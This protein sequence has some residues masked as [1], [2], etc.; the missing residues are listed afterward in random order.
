MDVLVRQ[1]READLEAL[2][3]IHAD[4]RTNVHWPEGAFKEM[5]QARK[6]LETMLDERHSYGIGYWAVTPADSD[7]VIGFSGLRVKPAGYSDYFNLYYRCTPEVWGQGIARDV[8]GRALAI[9]R[10]RWPE[11][12]V[13]ARMRGANLPSQRVA[14]SVGLTRAGHD[15]QGRIFFSDRRLYP[16]FMELLR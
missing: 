4:P 5:E 14:L 9:A 3:R 11:R 8:A 1:P 10:E 2:F 7:E 13:V 15:S 6:I 12:P 16:S